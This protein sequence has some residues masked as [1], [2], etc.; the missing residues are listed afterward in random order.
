MILLIFFKGQ[1]LKRAL[2][3]RT[4]LKAEIYRVPEPMKN[5]SVLKDP[6]ANI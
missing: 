2:F 4:R 6:P 3:I 1:I 5:K